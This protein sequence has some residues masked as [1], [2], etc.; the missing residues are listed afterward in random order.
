MHSN[1]DGTYLNFSFF[2]ACA[3]S[4]DC[5]LGKAIGS[6]YI[7]AVTEYNQLESHAERV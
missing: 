5:L 6:N 7:S 3:I 2:R 1:N 4:K